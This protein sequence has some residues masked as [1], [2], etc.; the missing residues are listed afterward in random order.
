M[1]GVS[2]PPEVVEL[3]QALRQLPGIGP[4]SAERIA[5]W[6]INANLSAANRLS[7]ALKNVSQSIQRCHRCGFYLAKDTACVVC[8]DVT[9]D[10]E[11]LCVVEQPTDLIALDRTGAYRGQFHCLGGKLSPLENVGPDELRISS[12]MDRLSNSSQFREVILALGSDVEGEATSNYLVDLVKTK[13]SALSVS[14]LAQ[15]LPVGGGLEHADELTLF[16]AL[17]GRQA[18]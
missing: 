5:V 12:L 17:N 3:V 11:T 1:K 9:R 15:G 18:R 10:G 14:Q 6:T 16:R 7:V 13:F 2:F 4:R 8:D